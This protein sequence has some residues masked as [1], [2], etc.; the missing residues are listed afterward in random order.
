MLY[1]TEASIVAAHTADR[2]KVNDLIL[3]EITANVHVF[4]LWK[5][6]RSEDGKYHAEKPRLDLNFVA[7]QLGM[8]HYMFKFLA[9][10]SE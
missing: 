8:P 3:I 5:D 9:A 6:K 1:R 7:C 10:A 4:G 2:S